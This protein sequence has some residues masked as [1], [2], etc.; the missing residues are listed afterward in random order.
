MS[1]LSRLLPESQDRSPGEQDTPESTF[2]RRRVLKWAGGAML[3]MM[4]I[5][6]SRVWV[7]AAYKYPRELTWL[8]GVGLFVCVWVMLFTGQV[9]RWDSDG[10]WTLGIAAA[11]AGRFPLIAEGLT[12]L[13]LEAPVEA[14]GAEPLLHAARV[15]D[16][17]PS[18]QPPGSSPLPGVETGDLGFA[19]TRTA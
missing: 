17:G 13:I 2:G 15:L 11:I 19:N 7:T 18:D 14:G 1:I 16:S 9:L 4:I 5:H 12:R 8:A 10:F 6:M 3:V